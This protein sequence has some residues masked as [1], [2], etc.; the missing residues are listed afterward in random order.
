MAVTGDGWVIP[1]TGEI[2]TGSNNSCDITSLAS[3]AHQDGAKAYLTLG[4][5]ASQNTTW[6][7]ASYLKR[8]VDNPALLDLIISKTEQGHYDGVILDYET[9][10][11]T[12]PDISK[13]FQQYCIKLR[14]KLQAQNPALPLGIDIIHKTGDVDP[15]YK[16]NAFEDWN[17]LGQNG[18]CDF[19][20]LM[21][22]DENVAQPGPGVEWSW[23]NAQL[24]YIEKTMP[25]ALPKTIWLFPAYGVKWQQNSDGSWAR[26]NGDVSCP[27]AL[28]IVT[29][30][31]SV[32]SKTDNP[33]PMIE[34]T[35]NGLHQKLWYNTTS[36][37][38]N[39]MTQL[40]GSERE[41]LHNPSF[42]LP[43]SFWYRGDECSDLDGQ[44][45]KFYA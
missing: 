45:A 35:F 34:Y 37:L 30:A 14:E 12:F 16:L 17:I 7:L 22:L 42:K 36:S 19:F 40:Q 24:Q 8:A 29:Q 21:S 20:V 5:D 2:V 13:I 27:T 18:V 43:V 38:I 44:L 25:Q 3:I 39:L 31:T 9:V 33:I 6:Q 26:I 15:F 4:V 11:V 41:I 1:D 23:V 10:D 28:N 32:Q